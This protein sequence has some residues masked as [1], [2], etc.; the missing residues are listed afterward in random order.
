[1]REAGRQIMQALLLN[2]R[3]CGAEFAFADELQQND[4]F[5]DRRQRVPRRSIPL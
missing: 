5:C 4:A 1:M 2:A 3:T